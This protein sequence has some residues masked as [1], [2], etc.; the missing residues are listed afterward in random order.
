MATPHDWSPDE[1]L[2]WST[3]SLP[4]ELAGSADDILHNLKVIEEYV[5]GEGYLVETALLDVLVRHS[6]D[7]RPKLRFSQS[8][9][10]SL[11][12][13]L[14]DALQAREPAPPEPT[15]FQGDRD[16]KLVEA[17]AGDVTDQP[18]SVKD[19]KQIREQVEKGLKQVL[20]EVRKA[21]SNLEQ[22]HAKTE[23]ETMS[24]NNRSGNAIDH[25]F[26][27]LLR[28]IVA[29]NPD[30]SVNWVRT[31]EERQRYVDEHQWRLEHG[32]PTSPSIP[33]R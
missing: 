33:L 19:K 5:K 26:V 21:K 22:M 9:T 18:L 31:R 3:W 20:E 16:H 10:H 23:C 4:L 6:S 32:Q 29:K 25:G 24:V 14:V 13:A 30:G 15:P 7:L 17:R 8:R 2:A 12:E 27:D 28:Q 1:K 11:A